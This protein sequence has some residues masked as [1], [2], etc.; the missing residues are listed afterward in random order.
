MDKACSWKHRNSTV[1]TGRMYVLIENRLEEDGKVMVG[2]Y[3]FS[4]LMLIT[5]F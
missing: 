4:I 1:S 2:L 5:L 3:E